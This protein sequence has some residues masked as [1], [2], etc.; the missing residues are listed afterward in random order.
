[1]DAHGPSMG[2]WT[3]SPM[4]SPWIAH[5]LFTGAHRPPMARQQLVHGLPMVIPWSPHILWLASN[6]SMARLWSPHG[7]PAIR[8]WSSHGPPMAKPWPFCCPSI[9]RLSS[10]I[11]SMVRSKKEATWS[12]QLQFWERLKGR[13]WEVVAS[14]HAC[15]TAYPA[16]PSNAL[17]V[18][19]V[20][21]P[22][23]VASWPS[24]CSAL[25]EDITI[26]K[27]K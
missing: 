4:D 15:R 9:G 7:S 8:P 18:S 10:V 20:P 27:M 13:Q 5:G 16:A 6:S 25:F 2:N 12:L 3:W 17:I 22:G 26:S 21:L 11:T 19:L 23:Y 1:M 14:T 24:K